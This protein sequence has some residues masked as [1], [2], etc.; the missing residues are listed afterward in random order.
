MAALTEQEA[1]K[2][3]EKREKRREAAKG[4]ARE[5]GQ[6]QEAGFQ[7]FEDR[8]AEQLIG[9]EE[10]R[11]AIEKVGERAQRRARETAAQRLAMTQAAGAFG[12]GATGAALRGEAARLS[13][14]EADLMAENVLLQ[15]RFKQQATTRAAQ[16]AEKAGEY[17]AVASAQKAFGEEF[18]AQ[19]QSAPEAKQQ[20]IMET[21]ENIARIKKDHKGKNWFTSDDEEGAAATMRQLAAAESD[22]EIKKMYEDEAKRIEEEG[23][24]AF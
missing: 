18:A 4:F 9:R 13:D 19:A 15:E 5:A 7:D 16:L 24:F 12:G 3:E 22:P 8:R 1:K 2:I 14:A 17:G 23:D 20:R 10:G 11:E 6:R 21:T